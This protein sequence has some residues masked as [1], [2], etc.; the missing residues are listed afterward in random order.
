[1]TFHPT[2][3]S[4]ERVSAAAGGLWLAIGWLIA[5]CTSAEVQPRT[6]QEHMA[7][8]EVVAQVC[9][10]DRV[11][12]LEDRDSGVLKIKYW[13]ASDRADDL[14]SSFIKF[15]D[16]LVSQGQYSAGSAARYLWTVTEKNQPVFEGSGHTRQEIIA[17]SATVFFGKPP[18]ELVGQD[19]VT[20][21][22]KIPKD[23]PRGQFTA[24][25][26]P[27]SEETRETQ[28]KQ[29][30]PTFANLTQGR[31]MEIHPVR[32]NA[33]K[34]RYTLMSRQEYKD[35]TAPWNQILAGHNWTRRELDVHEQIRET[36]ILAPAT[37]T[38][39]C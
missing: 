29:K 4:K 33:A 18:P 20:Y 9:L 8:V 30:N 15:G 19:F 25:Q 17:L 27:V 7:V 23:I 28:G 2:R 34:M 35:R 1:M 3:Q 14:D 38:P 26:D 37:P 22:F 39:G 32:P 36:V 13:R 6:P 16:V 10:P 21:W 11:L 24:W 5:G 31:P 12:R